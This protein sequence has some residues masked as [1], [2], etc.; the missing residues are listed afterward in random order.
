MLDEIVSHQPIILRG[1][2]GI[3]IGNDRFRVHVLKWFVSPDLPPKHA[4][5]FTT[6]GPITASVV[7]IFTALRGVHQVK[8][9]FLE[10]LTEAL[11]VELIEAGVE[12]AE[13]LRFTMNQSHG[14]KYHATS[15]T[16]K[17]MQFQLSEKAV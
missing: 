7:Q 5:S 9:F 14:A 12:A 13:L 6:F 11:A 2:D 10:R 16:F 17:A 8:R 1:H 3:T 4:Q 15:A